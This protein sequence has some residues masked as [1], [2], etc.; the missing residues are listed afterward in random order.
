MLG[1]PV[2]YPPP[3]AEGPTAAERA[4]RTA[5]ARKQICSWLLA[6]PNMGAAFAE[7][8]RSATGAG[9]LSSVVTPSVSLSGGYFNV[10]HSVLLSVIGHDADLKNITSVVRWSCRALLCSH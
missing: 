3:E 6:D 9:V 8:D 7:Y 5:Q 4:A 1:V 10:A 2:W